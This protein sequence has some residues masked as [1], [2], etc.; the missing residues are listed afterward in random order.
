MNFYQFLMILNAHKKKALF[1]FF[2]TVITTVIVSLIL[3]KTYSA[4]T[5][6]VINYAEQDPV[7]GDRSPVQLMS[8]YIAT[9]VDV[10]SSQSVALKVVDE[11]DLSNDA[12]WI[13]YYYRS[14]EGKGNIRNWLADSLLDNLTVTPSREGGVIVLEFESNNARFAALA[15]NTFAKSYIETN[16]ELKIAP[17]RRNYTWFKVQV[18]SMRKTL[19]EAKKKLSEYQRKKGIISLDKRLDVKK[20]KYSQLSGQLVTSQT[21]LVNLE[22][23]INAIKYEDMEGSSS[24]LTT[25]PIIM[26]IKTSLS[27]VEIKYSELKQ[28]VSSNHPSY[29]NVQAEIVSL[30]K[31]LN[32]QLK[33]AISQLKTRVVVIK[34]KI[35]EIKG[36]LVKQK[37][38]LLKI[39][40]NRD[41]LDILT[42]DVEDA[43]QILSLATKRLSQIDL[44]GK[45][46][47]GNVSVLSPAIKPIKPIKP[48]ILT[49][50]VL[51]VF[52]G[53]ILSVALALL[54]EMV[55]RKVRLAKDIIFSTELPVLGDIKFSKISNK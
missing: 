2:V 7:T 49:N 4:Q 36:S 13:K 1:A 9:Q 42:R 45:T 27:R 43:R 14:T 38:T 53:M 40:K 50:I 35:K 44:E 10:I 52:F 24:E 23:K 18:S 15:S 31:K 12:A 54:L 16:L 19:I 39:N 26:E 34:S 32:H 11:L 17:S 28:R 47:E 22:S 33:I 41:N 30:K 5:S 8:S 20:A 55:N 6:V 37:E 29:K 46:Q 25:D 3:P 51:S 21:E 48:N